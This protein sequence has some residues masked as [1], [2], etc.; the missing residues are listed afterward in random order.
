VGVEDNSVPPGG[1][2]DSVYLP[3]LEADELCYIEISPVL[4]DR[5][6]EGGVLFGQE[7]SSLPVS[8]EGR[9]FVGFVDLEDPDKEAHTYPIIQNFC[10]G[11]SFL[12]P[13]STYRFLYDEN[14]NTKTWFTGQL[15]LTYCSFFPLIPVIEGKTLLSTLIGLREWVLSGEDETVLLPG[16]KQRKKEVID[17]WQQNRLQYLD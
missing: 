14:K 8:Y 3:D 4:F 10:A 16:I 12:Y 13:S 11:A 1:R 9:V 7:L 17:W 6:F 15:Y 5:G 2:A